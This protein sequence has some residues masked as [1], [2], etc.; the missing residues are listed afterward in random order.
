MPFASQQDGNQ[1]CGRLRRI[2]IP[3]RALVISALPLVVLV[4][5]AL[6]YHFTRHVLR[7]NSTVCVDGRR[8]GVVWKTNEAPDDS[9]GFITE[10]PITNAKVNAKDDPSSRTA[11]GAWGCL[12]VNRNERTKVVFRPGPCILV[13]QPLAS[14]QI[15][16]VFGSQVLGW[17]CN[18]DGA[19]SEDGTQY[20]FS[21]RPQGGGDAGYTIVFTGEYS[22]DE[23]IFTLNAKERLWSSGTKSCSL[24][25]QV[26]QDGTLKYLG[27]PSDKIET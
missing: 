1:A 17:R 14:R 10:N 12:F 18:L 21:L 3:M 4:L 8:V 25:Y 26:N 6:G 9:L 23:R 11:A 5:G 15:H 22:P 16:N 19:L 13:N 7:D 27:P 20:C 24:R 2:P